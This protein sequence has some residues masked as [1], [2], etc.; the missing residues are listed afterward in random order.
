MSKQSK[1]FAAETDPKVAVSFLQRKADVWFQDLS[2]NNYLEKIKNSWLSYHG[3]YYGQAHQISYGGETGELVNL[4]VNHYRNIANHILTMTT[5]SRPAFQA[6]SVNTDYKSQV[7]TVL[8]NG[9][10]DYYMREKRLEIY[11]K[12]SVEY[13]IILGAGFI[14]M[15][16]NATS[17]EIYDYIEPNEEEI[18]DY[19]EDGNALDEDG[20]ILNPYP[21]YQG[22][23]DFKNL[24][25]F[26]VVFDSTKETYEENEWVVCR[27]FKNKYDLAEK[28]P[29]FK[30]EIIAKKTKSDIQRYTINFSPLD[31]TDDIPVYEFF[32][33][34]T[35]TLPSGRYL[36]Y[37]E[38]DTVLM[39]T[40]MPYRRLPVYRISPSDILGTA[41]GYTGMFDL[42]PIQDS[43]NSLYSTILTNQNAF[44]VQSIL[45]PRGNDIRVSQVSEGMNFI[46]YNPVVNGQ[47]G[48]PEPLNLTQTPGE[49][50]NFAQMLERTME[51]LSGVNATARGNPEKQLTSG[52]A[53]A[54]VQSQA[55]QYMSGLQQSYIMLIEDIGTGLIQ[56]LQDF[57]SV[58]RVAEIAGKSNKT[59]MQEF[60]GDDIDS[61]SRVVVDVGNALAQTTAGRTQMADNLIQMGLIKT[62]EQYMSVINTGKLETMTEGQ[63]DHNLLIRAE[64]ERLVAG[65]KEVI[66]TAI[67]AHS[68][69]IREH[70]NILADPDLRLDPD[71]VARVLAHIQE[72]I[73]LSQTTDP[74]LLSIIGEQP[75]SPAGGT[76]ISPETA[77]GP[78][79][80][81]SA[82]DPS[83]VMQDPNAAMNQQAS[84]VGLPQPA[85]PPVDPQTGQPLQPSERPIGS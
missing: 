7:Q 54:L 30:D 15:E 57:A 79:P 43:L 63:L 44:G 12:R 67:D 70:M 8:A 24:S 17:G 56:L 41:Y 59:K 80:P 53:L 72:H 81:A 50:F 4:P 10:L 46:E 68:Q 69:H 48:K 37:L 65:D 26:D 34:S 66:A 60:V 35:E 22:D 40:P 2:Y 20:N 84:S 9:L 42:L 18:V 28:Y 82:G 23:V 83:Q 74:N 32:H 61:I 38:G 27:T 58:P 33:K 6:K 78:Q 85:Q 55:L 14:K 49:I 73:D 11:L 39:D 52:N 76:P 31:E 47:S 75:L 19:D 45:N 16:W 77:A 13:A 21:I 5:A 25:P 36:L 1:Y 51:T 64:N 3:H 71:L 62:V 29:E